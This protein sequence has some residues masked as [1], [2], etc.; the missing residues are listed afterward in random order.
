MINGNSLLPIL[1]QPCLSRECLMDLSAKM[2]EMIRTMTLMTLHA[3]INLTKE[4]NTLFKNGLFVLKKTL[5]ANNNKV[6]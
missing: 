6:I 3:I 1:I 4:P 2:I 5:I